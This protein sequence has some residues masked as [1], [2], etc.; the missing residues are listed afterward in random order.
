LQIVDHANDECVFSVDTHDG[1][2]FDPAHPDA[3][4]WAELQQSNRALKE[5]IE[6][7]WEEAGLLTFNALLRRE[8]S[9]TSPPRNQG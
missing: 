5:Q 1:I 7:A 9:G 3:A 8:L 6:H 2:F 4:N